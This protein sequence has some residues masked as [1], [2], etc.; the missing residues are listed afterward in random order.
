MQ[1][2]DARP[3]FVEKSEYAMLNAEAINHF[4]DPFPSIRK[5]AS[6][7]HLATSTALARHQWETM[8]HS[9]GPTIAFRKCHPAEPKRLLY[10]NTSRRVF[11]GRGLLLLPAEVPKSPNPSNQGRQYHPVEH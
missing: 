11:W 5:F 7:A 1:T 3:R 4:S 8:I 6:K 10:R 2:K 9:T